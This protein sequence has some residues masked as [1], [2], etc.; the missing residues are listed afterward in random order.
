MTQNKITYLI[1]LFLILIG[2]SIQAQ[3]DAK[4]KDL[5]NAE[6]FANTSGSLIQKEFI[7]IGT[8]NKSEFKV[9]IY[10]DLIMQKKTTAL[11][12][13]K[14]ISGNYPKTKT[15]VL[16][17]DEI[18]GLIKSLNIIKDKILT[19]TVTNYTEVAYKSRSSFEAG[20]Y[21]KDDSWILFMRLERY[22]NDSFIFM[23]KDD[24]PNLIL[25]LEKAK[26]AMQ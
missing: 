22:D 16:D 20:C 11:K 6:I 12:I 15:A 5:S 2:N 9:V 10:N 8:F 7:S 3:N 1:T 14:E 19:T 4:T 13:T 18:E 24:L 23:N 26:A 17:A 25:L 21:S